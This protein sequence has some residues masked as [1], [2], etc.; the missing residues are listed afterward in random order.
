MVVK[1][2]IMMPLVASRPNSP[3]R[4]RRVSTSCAEWSSDTGTKLNYLVGTMIELPR[5]AITADELA[6]PPNSSRFGTNDLTQTRSV[7]AATTRQASS[8]ITS[9]GILAADPF[10]SIDQEG[11][12]ELIR[13]ATE[14]GRKVRRKLKLGISGEHGGD[15]ASVAYLRRRWLGLCVLLSIPGADLPALP[16]PKRR[17]VNARRVRGSSCRTASS[18]RKRGP[19]DLRFPRGGNERWSG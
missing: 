12:G 10:V 8:G 9:K 15:P 2:E 1:P 6:E 16:P 17:W 19:G 7:S 14:R 13:I 18:S 11:V 5:A 4:S 3:T